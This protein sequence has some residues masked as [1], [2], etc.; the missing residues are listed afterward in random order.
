M[1]PRPAQANDHDND[2]NE[3]DVEGSTSMP[4][5]STSSSDA[6]TATATTTTTT[7][8]AGTAATADIEA[9][10]SHLRADWDFVEIAFA[11]IPRVGRRNIDEEDDNQVIHLSPIRV[12]MSPNLPMG[13]VLFNTWQKL[14]V[15]LHR[16]V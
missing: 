15:S 2:D 16:P 4:L 8:I 5:R 3:G 9:V 14:G 13:W 11:T 7:A 6:A 10:E 1:E 12:K